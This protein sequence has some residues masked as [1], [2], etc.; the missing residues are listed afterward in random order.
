[1]KPLEEQTHYE[2]LEVLPSTSAGD[3]ERAYRAAMSA[4]EPG[5]LALYSVFD[6]EDS[7]AIRERIDLAYRVLS[8]HNARAAYD[9]SV[10]AT[11][12]PVDPAQAPAEPPPRPAEIPAPIEEFEDLDDDEDGNGW[13]GARL[14][15]ARL[16]RGVDLDHVSV[17]TKINLSHLRCIEEERYDEL[18]ATVYVRGFVDAY[19]RSIGLDPNRVAAGYMSRVEEARGSARPQRIL[20]RTPTRTFPFSRR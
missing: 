11:A 10:R 7:K 8:D 3:I 1:M 16:S 4:F 18:P 15:R 14:R 2:A 19:A 5:S 6:A 17:A 9:A 13:T 12:P 20:G